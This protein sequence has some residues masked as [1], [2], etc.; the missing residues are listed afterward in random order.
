MAG[1]THP[2]Y[3]AKVLRPT[4]P[5]RG[6]IALALAVTALGEVDAL[7]PG[8]FS[9]HLTGPR[10]SVAVLFGLAALSLA[11]RRTCPL[12]VFLV[13]F[14][15]LATQALV[16]GASEGNGALIPALVAT[17]SVAAYGSRRAA[18]VALA[19]VPLVMALR[20]THNPSNIDWPT[21]RAA[22]AWDLTIVVAWLLGSWVR[23]R[24]MYE[25]SLVERAAQAEREREQ[26][27]AVA[28]AAERARMARELHDSIA[29]SLTVIVVQAEAADDALDRDAESARG[30]LSHIRATGR[31]A[32]LEMRQVIGALRGAEAADLTTHRGLRGIEELVA[33]AGAAGLS[34]RLS[35]T[36]S[37]EG[38]TPAVDQAAYRV[39]QEALTNALRHSGSGEG[40]GLRGLWPRGARRGGV[41]RGAGD[42]AALQRGW[43]W[44]DRHARAGVDVRRA[45]PDRSVAR[46]WVPRACRPPE[47]AA[48]MIR[49][50]LADDQELLRDGFSMILG[51]QP[52]LEV[53]G[54]ASDGDE[55]V[56]QVR[57]HRPD[58]VLMDIRMPRVDGLD[59]TVQILADV[60]ETR[61]LVLT[62]FD[63][64]EYVYR[65]LRAGASGFLLKDAPRETLIAAVRS[66]AAGGSMLSPSITRRLV[67]T[68]GVPASGTER[69]T[70]LSD[71]E[72]EV[73]GLIA[74]G[75]SN[76]EIATDLF[77]SEATVKSHVAH[78]LGKTGC[79]DRVHLVMLAYD[80]GLVR[81][82]DRGDPA[83]SWTR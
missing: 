36:G 6:D 71:R 27:T 75:R 10:W 73:L 9:T 74:R 30:P 41:G 52:D 40:D 65:A 29:H 31:E 38:V 62:T 15:L 70:P 46:R 2:R 24:R 17:Y 20:E 28:V 77:L 48:T 51:G 35:I 80:S 32:L 47:R 12:V 56:E 18:Y 78:I 34:T 4:V 26:S 14:S 58:V 50:V 8:L 25:H 72:R 45:P 33:S 21:T 7:A 66:V 76:R 16:Y 81:T 54:L 49:I 68:F 5:P 3:R 23:V 55:A 22:L 1:R 60:P 37:P 43:A 59:A 42:P 69:V 57:E 63:L 83:S 53:V 61:V 64:D 82:G 13:V 19:L 79:R 67:E 11:W 44:L 39:V